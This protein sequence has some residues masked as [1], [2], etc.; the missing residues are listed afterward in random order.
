MLFKK[1]DRVFIKEGFPKSSLDIS[2]SGRN[3]C[4]GI[5]EE[6]YI[7]GNNYFYL[8]D[9]EDNLER[10]IFDERLLEGVEWNQEK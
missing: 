2:E 9:S 6:A 1:G 4:Y 5:I 10:V 8:V 3:P 7:I